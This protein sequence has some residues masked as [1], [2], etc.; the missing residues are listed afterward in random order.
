MGRRSGQENRGSKI[1]VGADVAW[2]CDTVR[3]RCVEIGA[4]NGLDDR[5]V[6]RRVAAGPSLDRVNFGGVGTSGI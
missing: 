2:K 5:K 1:R 4:V 6:E 3:M